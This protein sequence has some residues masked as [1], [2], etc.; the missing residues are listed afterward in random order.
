MSYNVLA[1]SYV[2]H[3]PPVIGYYGVDLATLLTG[4]T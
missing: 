4:R 3:D 2:S 1:E